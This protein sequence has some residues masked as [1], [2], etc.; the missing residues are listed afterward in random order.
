M[1]LTS[2]VLA[3][4]LL[5]LILDYTADGSP[6]GQKA[7]LACAC[8]NHALQSM[9]RKRIFRAVKV[10]YESLYDSDVNIVLVDA[11]GT[12]GAKFRDLIAASPEIGAYVQELQ[13][14]VVSRKDPAA[15]LKKFAV[16]SSL[17]VHRWS[18][19]ERRT[20]QFF[21]DVISHI[22]ELDLQL[23]E[24]FPISSFF[25]RNNLRSLR[26][27][28][29]V[30][31]P[32]D[33]KQ[34]PTSKVVLDFLDVGYGSG[35]PVDINSC[36]ASPWSPFSIS[37]LRTLRL[38]NPYFMDFEI[39]E[40]LALCSNTLE[41]LTLE[42][43]IFGH[44]NIP[45]PPEFPK[46]SSLQMLRH[47]TIK[48]AIHGYVYE[49]PS[50]HSPRSNNDISH[51]ASMLNSLPTKDHHR[52]AIL[53]VDIIFAVI[54]VSKFNITFPLLPWTDFIET[55]NNPQISCYLNHVN[56]K[57]HRF[58]THGRNGLKRLHDIPTPA[59]CDI[60]D[61]NEGLKGLRQR[62]ILTCSGN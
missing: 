11:V 24:L 49:Q 36:F 16:R 13:V 28:S 6:E 5:D 33:T 55:L 19:F 61:R 30:W 34:T 57:I 59:L 42:V 37:Q 22:Q 51:I 54:D 56:I 3:N 15:K 17:V 32:D 52:R 8:V 18:T 20:Q 2:A 47:L 27:P 35:S 62:G 14:D 39:N 43:D 25:G 21:I 9:S 23:F 46:L 40:L 10:S 12:T 1:A 53:R 29:L 48:S 44:Y 41:S 4:E 50:S 45:L 26:V 60:L 7:L 58:E 31:D 38:S